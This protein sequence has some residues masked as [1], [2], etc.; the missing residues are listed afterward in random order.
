MSLEKVQNVKMNKRAI[1][2]KFGKAEFKFLCTAYLPIEIYLPAKFHV[3]ISYFPDKVQ[4]VKMN[5]GQ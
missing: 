5:K 1:T 3:D 2:K 4:N